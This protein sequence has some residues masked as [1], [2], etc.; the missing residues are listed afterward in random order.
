MNSSGTCLFFY[1][2]L[3]LLHYYQ[4]LEQRGKLQCLR[5]SNDHDLV[6]LLP[7]RGG[8]SCA[9]IFCCNKN[10]YRH[11]GIQLRLK[12]CSFEIKHP[13][14]YHGYMSQVGHDLVKKCRYKMGWILTLPC[15]LCCCYQN[16]FLNHS[17]KEYVDRLFANS[18]ELRST[19]LSEL[20]RQADRQA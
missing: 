16:P 20:Y 11:V 17:C 9:Y 18:K 1:Y 7:D 8:V 13:T 6:T 2:F 14:P 3:L 19:T 5:V 10:I 15:H 12:P 4:A